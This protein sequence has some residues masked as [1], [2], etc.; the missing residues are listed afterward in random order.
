MPLYC[1]LYIEHKNITRPRN[2]ATYIRLKSNFNTKVEIY[3]TSVKTL[4]NSRKTTLFIDK[5]ING[6]DTITP[7]QYLIPF[8][9]RFLFKYK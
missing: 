4:Q 5:Q 1:I 9:T 8:K 6:V 3:T 7:L 2:R